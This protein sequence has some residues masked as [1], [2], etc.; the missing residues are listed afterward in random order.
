M[1]TVSR[2]H[3]CPRSR[4]GAG[5]IAGTRTGCSCGPVG[6]GSVTR[7]FWRRAAGLR[8]GDRRATT[9]VFTDD[10]TV[11]ETVLLAGWMIHSM[12]LWTRCWRTS[13]T[14]KLPRPWR[15][16]CRRCGAVI[17]A[18]A[19]RGSA[20]GGTLVRCPAAGQTS[21]L[22]FDQVCELFEALYW[23]EWRP[24]RVRRGGL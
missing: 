10:V 7:S 24:S 4:R 21:T 14:A 5:D 15:R 8:D 9:P 11:E 22:I 13:S 16:T 1:S 6:W 23:I 19:G 18:C 12:C 20:G 3:V 17:V 2:H